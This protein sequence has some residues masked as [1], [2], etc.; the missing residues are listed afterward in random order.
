VSEDPEP[1]AP[2]RLLLQPLPAAG[3]WAALLAL[4]LLLGGLLHW[5]KL[6]GALLLGPLA[7]AILVQMACGT[8]KV[9]HGALAAAQ[10]VIGCLVAQ[11]LTPA[12]IGGFARCWPVVLGVV[13][14]TV[15]ASAAIGWTISRL[16]IIPGSTAVWG[17]LPGAATVMMVMAEAY[18]ADF[19]LVAF[20]QYLRVVLVAGAAS[21]VALVFVHD[22]G[23]RF[24]GG[25]FPPV[26]LADLAATAAVAVA[27]GVLGRASGM[28]AGILLGPLVLGAV[29]NV[30]GWVR[31]E[32]P[33]AALI[34]SFA[35]IGW[36]TGLRFT[37]D[38]LAAA[39]RA[40]PQSVGATVLLMAFCGVLA[41]LLV[42]LLHVDPLTAYLA[43]SPGGMD[44]AAIIAASTKV[45]VPFVMA[46]QAVRLIMLIVAGPPVA[47]WVAGALGR[48]HPTRGRPPGPEGP[49]GPDP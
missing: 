6:P 24:A 36:N 13:A 35:L 48:T 46:L 9:P 47:R 29:L 8:V 33:P 42:V 15:A 4:S 1:S 7:A 32:L 12:I 14:L 10:M 20:M 31:I 34:A 18:G 19:R 23:G 49:G 30:S 37:P 21:V 38:V 25:L 41:W 26:D 5:A 17:M 43:T 3:R 11:S 22:G 2:P 39:A 45:D 27:G 44:A 16:R 28:P 40:L